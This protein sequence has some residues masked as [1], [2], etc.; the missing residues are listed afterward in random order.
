M[1]ALGMKNKFSIA[2]IF[3]LLVSISL[4]NTYSQQLSK[5][6]EVPGGGSGSQ[7]TSADSNDDYILYIVGGAVIAGVII[8]ALLKDKKEKPK[9][10]TTAVIL[11]NDFL[12][13][14]LTLSEKILNMQ[15]QIPINIS[16][17][18]Q[19]NRVIREEKRYYLGLNYN[20]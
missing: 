19:S 15:S 2:V 18:L 12:R 16:F 6:F 7:S 20:F 17:G 4:S 5:V 1:R 14:N 10:D 8:Y 11:N 9:E 13:K 3:F